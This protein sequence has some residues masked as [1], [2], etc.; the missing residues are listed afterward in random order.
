MYISA[1]WY[2]SMDTESMYTVVD[3]SGEIVVDGILRTYHVHLPASYDI[4][5]RYSL[6]LAFHGGGGTGKGMGF[7]Q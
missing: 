6:L 3:N 4:T 7:L 1:D 5:G 2:M